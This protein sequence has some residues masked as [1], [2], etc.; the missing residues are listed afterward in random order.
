MLEYED[1][2]VSANS[3]SLFR[4]TEGLACIGADV[5][6]K[7]CIGADVSFK[8]CI[9]ADASFKVCTGADII[10]KVCIGADASIKVASLPIQSVK[11]VL[12]LKPAL[13]PSLS[14]N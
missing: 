6:F 14:Y 7:V 4:R 2:D 1:K 5:S 12:A 11:A 10:F 3:W 13:D 8:V 9:G